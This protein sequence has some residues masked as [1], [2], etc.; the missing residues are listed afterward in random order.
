MTSDHPADP[1]EFAPTWPSLQR[2]RLPEWF[3]DAKLGLFVHWGLYSVPG[4]APQVPDIQTM[5]RR[6]PP[7]RVL[8]QIPYAEWYRNS[9][10]IRGSPTWRHH[11]EVYGPSFGYDDFIPA[12]D[13]GTQHCDLDGIAELAQSM[14]AGYVVLTAKHADGFSLWPTAVDHPTKGRYRARRDLV[15]DLGDAVRAR[16]LR[17]GLYYCAGF[18]WAYQDVVM[19]RAA[20]VVLGMPSDPRY[21]AFADAQC[22]ELVDRYAPS[23]LWNDI[24]WPNGERLAALIAHYYATVPDGAINDRWAVQKVSHS[25]WSKAMIRGGGALVEALWRWIPDGK[26][27]LSFPGAQWCDFETEE[28]ASESVHHAKKWEATRGVGHSFGANRNERAADFLTPAALIQLLCDV[29][30]RNGNLLISVGPDERGVVPAAQSEPLRA[31][32]AWLALHR[33]AV[34]GSRPWA[35]APPHE[36]Q[37]YRFTTRDG[38]VYAVVL[39]PRAGDH[40]TLRGVDGSS[41]KDASLLAP[42]VRLALDASATEATFRLPERLVGTSPVVVVLGRGVR[43]LA[44]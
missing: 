12:F 5:I 32:G 24:G 42:S 14:G 37:P 6:Q 36:S 27:R 28:Y 8:A 16:G 13:E 1:D 4:W 44:P 29:V 39:S 26:K 9:M 31:L 38:I 19:R 3:D 43:S 40:V 33:E 2:H 34:V 10:A 7:R 22:R 17:L 23:V 35:A 41:V 20:D 25:L 15:G 11:R 30:G 18:D 21:E